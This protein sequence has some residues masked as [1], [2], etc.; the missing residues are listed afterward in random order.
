[1]KSGEH[2]GNF[3]RIIRISFGFTKRYR[4]SPER[5]TGSLQDILRVV[6]RPFWPCT[7]VWTVEFARRAEI[8]R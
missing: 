5:I 6:G 4:W 7:K 8:S 1:M 2:R 3:A